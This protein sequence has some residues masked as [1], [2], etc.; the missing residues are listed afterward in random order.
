MNMELINSLMTFEDNRHNS[1]L[2]SI[3]MELMTK[4]TH[5][6]MGKLERP[7]IDFEIKK[8]K[9]RNLVGFIAM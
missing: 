9:K 1:D 4:D 5:V 2:F 6:K 3:N 7:K 8:L